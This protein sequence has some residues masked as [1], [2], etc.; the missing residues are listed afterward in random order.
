MA[1]PTAGRDK[2]LADYLKGV[3]DAAPTLTDDQRFK[4][5]CIIRASERQVRDA[6]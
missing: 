6:S 4:L 5:G 1:S 3:V 2:K